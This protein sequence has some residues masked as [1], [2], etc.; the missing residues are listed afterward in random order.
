MMPQP[1]VMPKPKG[2]M[3]VPKPRFQELRPRIEDKPS[4]LL[5][6]ACSS[7]ERCLMTLEGELRA[8]VF[9]GGQK[10]R[11]YG[12]QYRY[13]RHDLEKLVKI[14]DYFVKEGV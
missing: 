10:E 9:I 3:A 2:D 5:D 4:A 1:K 14:R 8:R 6:D 11:K 7:I 13:L 12:P